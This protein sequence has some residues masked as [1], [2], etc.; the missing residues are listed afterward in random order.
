MDRRP[1]DDHVGLIAFVP[2]GITLCRRRC[3]FLTCRPLRV[4]Q[5]SCQLVRAPYRLPRSP[6]K[7]PDEADDDDASSESANDSSY[8]GARVA[9]TAAATAG[10][11][12]V[13]TRPTNANVHW[14][15]LANF[16]GRDAL[17]VRLTVARRGGAADQA[18]IRVRLVGGHV[19]LRN[20][21]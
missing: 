12:P 3:G 14:T 7:V 20:T 17:L 19:Q 8:S 2:R 13:V 9:S 1:L 18:A 6:P 16:D 21:A 11:I 4:G 15:L 5:R 10:T